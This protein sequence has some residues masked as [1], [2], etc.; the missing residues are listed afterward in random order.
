V[1]TACADGKARI[2]RSAGGALHH[3]LIAH[4]GPV[5]AVRFMPDGTTLATASLDGTVRFWHVASGSLQRTTS[6]STDP[7]PP[8]LI[9]PDSTRIALAASD[10]TVRMLRVPDRAVSTP[11]LAWTGG[12]TNL[13]VCRESLDVVAVNPYPAPDTV[14]APDSACR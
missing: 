4:R 9:S 1:A 7:I 5:R 14:W 13:R 8:L 11:T 2:F 12:R 10:G 6:G 3:T